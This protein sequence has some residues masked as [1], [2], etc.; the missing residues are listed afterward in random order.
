MGT[1]PYFP[2]FNLNFKSSCCNASEKDEKGH[3]RSV[4]GENLVQSRES[5]GLRRSIETSKENKVDRKEDVKM[6]KQSVV[7]QSK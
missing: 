4:D 6:V 1:S 3:I 2:N 5:R 7:V